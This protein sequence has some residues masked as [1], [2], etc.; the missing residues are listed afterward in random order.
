M[1]RSGHGISDIIQDIYMR[2]SQTYP[3]IGMSPATGEPLDKAGAYALQGLGKTLI[4][5]I[6][7]DYNAMIGL[8]TDA[9]VEMLKDFGITKA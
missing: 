4:E 8:P 3:V 5:K 1:P 7:G 9:L 2:D 6:E